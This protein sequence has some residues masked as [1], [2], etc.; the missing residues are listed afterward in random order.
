MPLVKAGGGEETDAA[1]A[2]AAEEVVVAQNGDD[3]DDDDAPEKTTTPADAAL[4]S[5]D[6]C[7]GGT[8]KLKVARGG[9]GDEAGGACTARLVPPAWWEPKA[10]HPADPPGSRC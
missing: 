4:D 1:A 8:A 7:V 3:A 2:E 5:G 9:A 10:G 6:S